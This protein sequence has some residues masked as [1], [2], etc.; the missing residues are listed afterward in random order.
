M[1]V[2]HHE[3]PIV[4]AHVV[5]W[6]AVTVPITLHGKQHVL[7]VPGE[8]RTRPHL[9]HPRLGLQDLQRDFA[10]VPEVVGQ[11]DGGHASLAELSLDG[12]AIC[13][14]RVE[15][16]HRGAGYSCR[17]VV[18]RRVASSHMAGK[19]RHSYA[20]LQAVGNLSHPGMDRFREALWPGSR[21]PPRSAS[22]R[23]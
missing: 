13:R 15:A 14:G 10:L 3:S 16:I 19:M 1:D 9:D 21:T 18:R 12:V 22:E 20:R 8:R 5:L 4:R 11:L 7:T 17:S 23:P 6:V 2:Q